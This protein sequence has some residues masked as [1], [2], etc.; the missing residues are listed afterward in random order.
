MNNETW[1]DD[2]LNSMRAAKRA[3]PNPF[4]FTRIQSKLEGE[5]SSSSRLWKLATVLSFTLLA[6]NVSVILWNQ[7]TPAKTST[8]TSSYFIETPSYQLY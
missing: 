8:E 3:E 4:L 5:I 6:L 7:K 1:K 2:I